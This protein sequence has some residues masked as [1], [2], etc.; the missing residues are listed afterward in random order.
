MQSSVAF[1]CGLL[2]WKSVLAI[3]SGNALLAIVRESLNKEK[4]ARVGRLI[5]L[6]LG[7]YFGA[8]A[9]ASP[10]LFLLF[11]APFLWLAFFLPVAALGASVLV[12]SVV[13]LPPATGVWAA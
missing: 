7:S 12:L 11:L 5:E 6:F 13:V 10:A 1:S 3:K 2:Q 9:V 4:A 8:V